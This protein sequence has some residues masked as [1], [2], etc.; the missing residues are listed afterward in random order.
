MCTRSGATDYH[1]T[2][3]GETTGDEEDDVIMDSTG[4]SSLQVEGLRAD[5][6][7]AVI[8]Y[9]VGANARLNPSGTDVLT[10]RTGQFRPKAYLSFV[11][12]GFLFVKTQLAL[13]NMRH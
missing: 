7:Y 13:S 4:E 9:S 2:I 8:V 12:S 10:T 1:V 5:R 6:V 3:Q 11:S